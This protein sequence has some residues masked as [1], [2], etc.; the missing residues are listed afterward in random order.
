MKGYMINI[1]IMSMMMMTM[2]VMG[3]DMAVLRAP[4][5]KGPDTQRSDMPD[6][7]PLGAEWA[8]S[9]RAQPTTLGLQKP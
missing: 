8:D 4:N 5:D 1:I 9:V 7:S 6:Q 3:D 2:M